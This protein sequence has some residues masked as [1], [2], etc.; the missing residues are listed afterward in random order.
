[1]PNYSRMRASVGRRGYKSRHLITVDGGDVVVRGYL[2]IG[3]RTSDQEVAVRCP[4]AGHNCVTIL[5]SCSHPFDSTPAVFVAIMSGV[6][7]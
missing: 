1:M 2:S 5:G 3:R 4:D 6:V 7:R